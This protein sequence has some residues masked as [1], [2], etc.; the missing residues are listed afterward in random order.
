LIKADLELVSTMKLTFNEVDFDIYD[1]AFSQRHAEFVKNDVKPE[2]EFFWLDLDAEK[3]KNEINTLR[4]DLNIA[5]HM[6]MDAS[7]LNHLHSNFVQWHDHANH[8]DKAKLVEMNEKIHMY[9]LAKKGQPDRWGYINGK[10]T[11]RLPEDVYTRF[12]IKRQFGHLY[13]GYTHV[14]KHFAEIV[15][16]MDHHLPANQIVPQYWARSDFFIWLGDDVTDEQEAAWMEKAQQTYKKMKDKMPY[17]FHDPKLAIGYIPFGKLTRTDWTR[18][19]FV[20]HMR[21]YSYK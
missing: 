16:S 15:E 14:G 11:Y 2:N 6:I 4:L 3:L 21:K 12:T 10:T 13:M 17:A 20:E 9:E 8:M 19:D 1:D 18:Q 7:L 5:T